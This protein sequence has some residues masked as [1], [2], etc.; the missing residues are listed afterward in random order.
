MRDTEALP[1]LA[2]VVA[3]RPALVLRHAAGYG[4]LLAEALEHWRAHGWQRAAL[5]ATG[6]CALVVGVLLAGVAALLEATSGADAGSHGM[7]LLGVSVR[8]W[9]L[10]LV[11][12]LPLAIAVIALAMAAHWPPP[13]PF[14]ELRRQLRADADLLKAMTR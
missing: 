6:A 9:T 7:G 1:Q 11:P 2:R 5:L 14:Q 10:V 3:L 12:V 4:A 8:T 13:D